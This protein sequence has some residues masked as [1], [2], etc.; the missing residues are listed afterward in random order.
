MSNLLQEIEAEIA[1]AKQTMAKRNVGA[2]REIGDGVAKVEGLAEGLARIAPHHAFLHFTGP[3]V[4][5]LEFA[6]LALLFGVVVFRAR[7]AFSDPIPWRR[8]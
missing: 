6:L 2:V 4:I 1:G 7:K 5:G 3:G 8:R